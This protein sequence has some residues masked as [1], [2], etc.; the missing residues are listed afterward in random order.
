MEAAERGTSRRGTG[1]SPH[2]QRPTGIMREGPLSLGI[3]SGRESLV[4]DAVP[5]QL[6]LDMNR[7]LLRL[8]CRTLRA[9][10]YW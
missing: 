7:Y 10:K 9:L 8:S 4:S 1:S 6:A 5:L 2:F 3:F